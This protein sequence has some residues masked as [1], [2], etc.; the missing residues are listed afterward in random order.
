[1]SRFTGPL[2]MTHLSA[3][4]R[5]W[6]LDEPLVY[7]VG[8]EGSGR[9]ITVPAGFETDGASV[10]RVLWWLL[11]TWG[12]YSRAAVVHDLLCAQIEVGDPHPHAPTWTA[13][14]AV[15]REAMNVS[16][17]DPVTRTVL[18]LAV[19]AWGVRRR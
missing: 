3:R 2:T 5:W 15:F 7:E 12:R 13:S 11:P 18:W 16:G 6:R 19:R 4:W 1:M 9:V 8:H 14:A 10:P 17:V